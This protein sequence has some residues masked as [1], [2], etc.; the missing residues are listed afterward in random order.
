MEEGR[1][2]TPLACKSPAVNAT[3]MALSL[4]VHE[5][6]EQFWRRQELTASNVAVQGNVVACRPATPFDVLDLCPQCMLRMPPIF[7]H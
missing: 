7:H 6:R 3:G 2:M 5:A 1:F 4:E